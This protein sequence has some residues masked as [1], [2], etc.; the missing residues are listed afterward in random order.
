MIIIS[1]SLAPFCRHTKERRSRRYIY[2]YFVGLHNI[3]LLLLLLA[4]ALTLLY[5]RPG[6]VFLLCFQFTSNVLLFS[7]EEERKMLLI[8]LLMPTKW[9]LQKKPCSAVLSLSVSD[10]SSRH[11]HNNSE[12]NTRKSLYK[13]P[14]YPC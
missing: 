3:E 1:I 14:I 2:I 7:I 13:A 10:L 4:A 9:Y 5:S 6:R 12:T 11:D 8:V